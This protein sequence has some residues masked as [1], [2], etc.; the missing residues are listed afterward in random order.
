M[1]GRPGDTQEHDSEAPAEVIE[2][3]E[4]CARFVSEAL[5]LQLDYSPETLPILDHYLAERARD[6]EAEVKQLLAPAAGAY[7]GEVARRSLGGAHW[8]CPEGQHARWRLQF[9]PFFLHFNPVGVAL[10]AI[11]RGEVAGSLAH[12]QVLDEAREPVQQSL[13]PIDDVGERD[14]YTLSVR[15]EVLEQVAC[16]LR[17]LES[18][19][20]RPRVFGAEVYR[21]T[22]GDP[23]Q[24]PKPS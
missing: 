7:F 4:A 23:G 3:A 17:A 22:N 2:L 24:E 9:S 11:E 15:Y 13:E 12:F 8:H 5:G 18:T 21:A 16:V 6:A 10:E 19:Q 20:D 14:Y 1:Q